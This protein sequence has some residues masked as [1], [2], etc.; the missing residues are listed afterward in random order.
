MTPI[1]A[2]VPKPPGQNSFSP[3]RCVCPCRSRAVDAGGA[4]VS[5]CVAGCLFRSLFSTKTLFTAVCE[6][7]QNAWNAHFGQTWVSYAAKKVFCRTHVRFK[8]WLLGAERFP[9]GINIY[10][11]ISPTWQ[12]SPLRRTAEPVCL[13]SKGAR[14]KSS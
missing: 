12:S 4:T 2:M 9:V 6:F 5:N 1:I 7:W 8:G 13:E 10:Y 11:Y 14:G 3:Q